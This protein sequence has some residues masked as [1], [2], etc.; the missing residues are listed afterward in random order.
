MRSAAAADRGARAQT[1]SGAV[2]KASNARD[3]GTRRSRVCPEGWARSRGCRKD[4]SMRTPQCSAPRNGEDQPC[5]IISQKTSDCDVESL[6]E[7]H[8]ASFRKDIRGAV[9]TDLIPES[10]QV[11]LNPALIFGHG[12]DAHRFPE[13]AGGAIQRERA[14]GLV[15]PE[16]ERRAPLEG[17]HH[18]LPVP[19]LAKDL[20]ALLE[21]GPGPRKL[22]LVGGQQAQLPE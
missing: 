1:S 18:S 11:F 3:A 12:L 6:L 20:E 7:R 4:R 21:I 8:R 22:V 13:G 14:I 10:A 16:F 2:D 17:V 15:L 9:R 5:G 19:H